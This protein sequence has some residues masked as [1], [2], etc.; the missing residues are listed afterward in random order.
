MGLFYSI[1]DKQDLFNLYCKV[2][3]TVEAEKIYKSFDINIHYLRDAAFVD[4]CEN[5]HLDIAKWLYSLGGVDIH[6]Y[7][8]SAFA[9]SYRNGYK[10]VTKWLYSLNEMYYKRCNWCPILK[11]LF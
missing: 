6:S 9:S 11:E 1:S 10:N 3:E 4:A 2:G 7:D 8:D 5:G